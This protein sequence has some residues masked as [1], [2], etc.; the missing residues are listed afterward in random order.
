MEITNSMLVPRLAPFQTEEW[1]V[2]TPLKRAVSTPNRRSGSA[3]DNFASK[4]TF[5]LRPWGKI[6]VF[7]QRR[8]I[9][10]SLIAL[11]PWPQR[12][13]AYSTEEWYKQWAETRRPHKPD[14]WSINGQTARFLISA[15]DTAGWAFN[16]LSRVCWTHVRNCGTTWPNSSCYESNLMSDRQQR[17]DRISPKHRQR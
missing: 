15:I 6:W 16:E 5:Y 17:G 11:E 9:L 13:I 2:P 12:S 8:L 7:I 14:T 1:Y 3:V 10:V 4:V